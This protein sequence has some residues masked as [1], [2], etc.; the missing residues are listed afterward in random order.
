[1]VLIVYRITS[2]V[3]RNATLLKNLLASFDMCQY[4]QDK[5]HIA[6]GCIDFVITQSDV[7][8]TNPLV[9]NIAFSDHCLVTRQLLVNLPEVYPIP[10]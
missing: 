4:D 10:V 1:M 2:I 6:G 8:V 9:A 7:K 5:T 3:N